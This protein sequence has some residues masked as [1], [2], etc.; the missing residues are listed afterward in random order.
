MDLFLDSMLIIQ[1]AN[2]INDK[3]PIKINS[4]ISDLI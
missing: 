2:N 3:T 4:F 1:G